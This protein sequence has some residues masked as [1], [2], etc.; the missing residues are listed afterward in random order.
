MTI[1]ELKAQSKDLLRNIEA[2]QAKIAAL[3]AQ[4]HSDIRRNDEAMARTKA[5]LEE[6][7]L[8]SPSQSLGHTQ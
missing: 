7:Q 3:R 4:L 2:T 5:R 6:L 1:T 8:G